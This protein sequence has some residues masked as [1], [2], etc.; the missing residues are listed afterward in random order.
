LG[1]AGGLGVAL[2][3]L[4]PSQVV[5]QEAKPLELNTTLLDYVIGW[6]K[7]R[8]QSRSAGLQIPVDTLFP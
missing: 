1:V 8:E 5:V 6:Q 3:Y 7:Q 2:F 4:P